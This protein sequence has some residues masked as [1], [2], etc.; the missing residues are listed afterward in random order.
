MTPAI[1]FALASVALITGCAAVLVARLLH[2]RAGRR[3][4]TG[5][6]IAR[7]APMARLLDSREAAFLAAQPGV[8]R[9]EIAQFRRERRR[10]FRMYLEELA[11]DYAALHREARILASVS[12][13]KNADL[14]GILMRQRFSFWM[15][16]AGVEVELALDAV[17][18]HRVNPA[19]LLA[20]VAELHAA[21]VRAAAIPGPVPVA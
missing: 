4:E 10:I 16:M 11:A 9:K 17:G 8:T 1:L 19:G 13:E 18:I 6:Q 21:I 14:L 12:S 20:N 5:F 2:Y 15:A 7:Y 3:E